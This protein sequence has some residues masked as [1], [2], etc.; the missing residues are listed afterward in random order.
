[1][2]ILNENP[3]FTKKPLTQLDYIIQI[4]TILHDS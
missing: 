3:Y 4:L 1:M 2:K